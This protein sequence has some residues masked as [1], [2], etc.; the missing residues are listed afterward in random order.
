MK[1]FMQLFLATFIVAIAVNFSAN[2][3]P[4][5]VQKAVI[6]KY[7]APNDAWVIPDVSPQWTADI[8]KPADQWTNSISN[9]ETTTGVN[10]VVNNQVSDKPS[11]KKAI[12]QWQ[13]KNGLYPDGIW[14]PACKA[15]DA[16]NKA[17]TAL[18][19]K[20]TG[21]QV[22][23]DNDLNTTSDAS[24][25]NSNTPWKDVAIVPRK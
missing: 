22:Y 11:G 16:A 19:D 3:N 5:N 13:K 8:A 7:A 20:D 12:M 21:Q 10:T 4:P 18:T 14:G 23:K 15:K 9:Q 6:E 17:N 1:K 2:A 24:G 25:A